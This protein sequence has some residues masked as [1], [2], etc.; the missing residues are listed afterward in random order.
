[1]RDKTSMPVVLTSGILGLKPGFSDSHSLDAIDSTD[2][3]FAHVCGGRIV[4]PPGRMMQVAWMR[5]APSER[6]AVANL[7][8]TGL[9]ELIM[10]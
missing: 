2:A 8:P 10:F 4:V 3:C 9:R 6:G 1:M 5:S 7:Y